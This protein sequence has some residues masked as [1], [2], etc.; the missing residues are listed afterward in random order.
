MGLNEKEVSSERKNDA[1]YFHLIYQRDIP[2]FGTI[3]FQDRFVKV[4]DS[5][6]DYAVTLLVGETDPVDIVD[7]LD[8]YDARINTASLQF[9]YTAIPNL[10]LETKFLIITQ[11]QFEAD[12]DKAMVLDDPETELDERLDFMLPLDQV[13]G[14]LNGRE[15]PFYPDYTLI[16]DSGNWVARQ[17]KSKNIRKQTTIIK[18]RYEIPLGN[19]PHFDKVGEDLAF[20][21]MVKYMWERYFDRTGADF[22]AYTDCENAE[23][24]KVTMPINPRISPNDEQV[25][26]Y[27]RFNKRTREDILGVRLDYQFTQRAAVLAGF[28]YRKFTNR[29]DNFRRY[30]ACWADATPPDLFFPDTRYRIYAIQSVNRGE[31]LGFNIVMLIGFQRQTWLV[32]NSGTSDTVYV[33]AMMGF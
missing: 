31:W 22:G 25:L 27:L 16:F 2:D 18:A 13:S 17:Y 1:R 26:E 21:P 28:Q 8:F 29:D 32:P 4:Q 10:S 12:V 7:R 15:Y 9:L 33:K 11:K 23:K 20:T 24:G 5:I 6:Y 3:L 14:E 19:L 30:L